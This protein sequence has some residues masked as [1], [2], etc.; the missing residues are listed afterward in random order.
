LHGRDGAEVYGLTG[1]NPLLV[2]ELLATGDRAVPAT[3][4]DL[5]QARMR[6]LSRAAQGVARLVSVM[7]TSADVMVLTESADAVDECV[8]AGVLTVRGSAVCYRHELLRQAVEQSLSPPRRADLHRRVLARI[9]AVDGVDPARLAHHARLGG[10]AASL[11]RFGVRAAVAAAAQ[12]AHR[13]AVAHYRAVRPHAALLPDLD[14]ADLLEAYAEQA[15]LAGVAAEGLEPIRA[16]IAE[17]QQLGDLAAV[18]EDLR[19]LSRLAWWS[20]D[21]QLAGTAAEQAVQVLDPLGPS[22]GLALA[23]SNL[24]QLHMLSHEM[25]L[26]IEWGN[27]ARD[28]ADRLDDVGASAHAAVNVGTAR[29]FS[30]RSAGAATLRSAHTTAAQAGQSDHAARALVNLTTSYEQLGD[31]T[32][33]AAALEEALT[34]ADSHELGG[35]VQYLLGV[36]AVIRFAH[37]D[38]ESAL[39]DAAESLDRSGTTGVAVVPALV[40]RGRILAARG[41]DA[42]PTLIR[43][44]EAAT[45]TGEIQRAGPVAA[46][47]AEFHLLGGAPDEAARRVRSALALASERNDPWHAE[48][49]AYWLWRATG[50]TA[51]IRGRSATPYRLLMAGRWADAAAAW[52]QLGD[53]YRGV[54]ALMFGDRDAVVKA[55]RMLDRVGATRVAERLRADLR[56]R[57]MTRVPRGPRPATAANPAGLTPRQLQVLALLS[58]GLTN[59]EIAHRLTLAPKTVEHHVAA[60]LDKLGASTRGQAVAVARQRSMLG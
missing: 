35:Y 36:R 20:A 37:G 1:G 46:A 43:A 47:W 34:Y 56:L 7:P 45:A 48:E 49:L 58:D 22:R 53:H 6:R 25:A 2:T 44:A 17:R 33:A 18:G 50:E 52:Q 8:A 60:V 23:Y 40:A 19:W 9:A 24:S 59:A 28:L 11:V 3:V 10:D 4:H 51:P 5:I 41:L 30:D 55:L 12:G 54:Q 13:E 32:A 15:Y 27:R 26:A 21:A 39:S 29:M 57:G 16:A 38:W 14:R 31:Y 42:M